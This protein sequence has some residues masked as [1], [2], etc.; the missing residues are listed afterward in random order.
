MTDSPASNRPT[1]IGSERAAIGN[2]TGPVPDD[3]LIQATIVLRRRNDT[4]PPA[5]Y[6]GAGSPALS[7]QALG[8]G[9]GAHPEDLDSVTRLLAARGVRVLHSHAPSRR[10]RIE[11]TAAALA[12]LFGARLQQV[13]RADGAGQSR[14]R[15]G[16]LTLPAELDGV[17]TA[18]LGLDDRPQAT[19]RIMF[20]GA[21]TGTSYTPL[22]VADLYQFPE[23]DGTGQTIAII[24]LGGGFA[25]SDLDT[26]FKGLGLTSPKVTAASVDGAKNAPGQ[27]PNGADGEVLLDIEVAGAV[28]PKSD[29]VV[30]FAPN[31]DDGFVDAVSTA[32]HATPTPT[33]ISISWGQSEDSWTAQAR[34]SLDQAIADAVA[35]GITVCSAAGDNGS[36]DSGSG[37]HTDF[38]S[39]SP[40][41]LACGGTTLRASGTT[42][43]S[44]TVWNDGGQGGSTGGGVSDVF[45]LPSYQTSAGVPQRSGA[46]TTGRGVPDVSANA[47]PETGYQV[48]VDGQ[49][50]VVGGTS[51]VAPLWA[52]LIA[53]LAQR[54][55][56]PLGL[57]QTKLYDGV[58]AGK[59]VPGL[60]D[61]TSGSNGA[62]QA[63]PGWDA[64]TGLGVPQAQIADVFSSN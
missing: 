24:E 50:T 17:V 26:Y 21:T 7:S 27:D 48:Y 2:A 53:R 22:Q 35:M 61:I 57:V 38:P 36:S 8:E 6:Y 14:M 51:A 56:G 44:E 19:P 64:C 46:T 42:V 4:P 1:L 39:S 45:E 52:G 37:V 33:A 54:A 5:H 62:Y 13:S 15:D 16:S 23:G 30:Y 10:V 34:Q 20:A 59:P 28:A 18:V 63:G 41:S 55:G 49:Q 47:D 40:S 3:E 12:D 11:G 43:T 32:A 29:I 9:Y 31:T 58:A 60:R 25:Q